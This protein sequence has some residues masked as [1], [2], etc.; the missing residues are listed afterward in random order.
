MGHGDSIKALRILSR[1]KGWNPTE[2][3]ADTNIVGD[4]NNRA[5]TGK[6]DS[7]PPNSGDFPESIEAPVGIR[8][9]W[10]PAESTDGVNTKRGTNSADP[11][12]GFG[13]G[14]R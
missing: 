12:P 6:F 14:G 7:I 1:A 8:I 5:G 4:I 13:T 3:I 11:Y 10:Q 2:F 9:D